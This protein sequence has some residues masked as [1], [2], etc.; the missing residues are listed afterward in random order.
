MM[1]QGSSF[2]HRIQYDTKNRYNSF[3]FFFCYGRSDFT[4]VLMNYM[5]SNLIRVD[6]QLKK[7]QRCW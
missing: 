7:L 2:S 3:F 1:F 5:P 6:L 4:F